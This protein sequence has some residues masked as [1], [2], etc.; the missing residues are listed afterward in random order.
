MDSGLEE[1]LW[2]SWSTS[3]AV[4]LVA[5]LFVPVVLW[6][7][8][9]SLRQWLTSSVLRGVSDIPSVS[10]KEGSDFC[11]RVVEKC[12]ILREP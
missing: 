8:G 11:E 1:G 9:N 5:M 3:Y 4:G 7:Y 6:L 10:H 12:P 2:S